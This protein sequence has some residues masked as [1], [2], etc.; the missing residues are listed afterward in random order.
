MKGRKHSESPVTGLHPMNQATKE[1][2]NHIK[3]RPYMVD[4]AEYAFRN[5][6]EMAGRYPLPK[7]HDW[8][9][10]GQALKNYLNPEVTRTPERKFLREHPNDEYY[11]DWGRIVRFFV[12]AVRER[13]A[14][15]GFWLR[16][17]WKTRA[18]FRKKT[19][20]YRQS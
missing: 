10:M 19:W 5:M 17:K 11:V 18:A 3:N 2:L 13:H 15:Q 6:I 14:K 16:D 12:R 4:Q 9:K 20:K 7:N 1:T 8:D